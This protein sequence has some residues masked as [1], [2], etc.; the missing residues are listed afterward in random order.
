MKQVYFNICIFIIQSSLKT[1]F[2][3][4]ELSRC[5]L[6][7]GLKLW[8]IFM[9]CP[10]KQMIFKYKTLVVGMFENRATN[11]LLQKLIWTFIS[12][13]H[14]CAIYKHWINYHM[15]CIRNTLP[16]SKFAQTVIFILFFSNSCLII[17]KAMLIYSL[18]CTKSMEVIILPFY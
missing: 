5:I 6:I 16:I 7:Q 1:S 3:D 10:N 4:M 12:F 11:V 15:A 14:D 13:V 2:R 17:L 18:L 8:L 9:L